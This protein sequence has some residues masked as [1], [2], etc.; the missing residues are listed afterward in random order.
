MITKSRLAIGLSK[1]RE[2]QSPKMMEEQHC[3]DSETAAEMLWNAY[4]LGDV[5]GKTMADLGCGTG[6][7]G[8]GALMLGARKT[9]FVEKD[10]EAIRILE[11]NL[12]GMGKSKIIHADIKDYNGKAD[13]VVQNPPFGTKKEHADREFLKKAFQTA[14][15]VYSIHKSSTAGFVEAFCSD[16]GFEI[17]HRQKV[18]MPLKRTQSFHL[19][20][21]HRIEATVF[22]M[23]RK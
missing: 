18:A 4:M 5:K 10:K 17:T 1:L 8:I 11:E 9:D 16:S 12:K 21:M 14:P 19:K 2:F 23:Q 3:T 15:V 13:V 20:N 22:R 6:I 7:L